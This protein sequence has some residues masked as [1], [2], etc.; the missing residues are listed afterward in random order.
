LVLDEP[1][2]GLDSEVEKMVLNA[3]CK[4][5]SE[6]TIVIAS[7]SAEIVSM[8][9]RILVIDKGRQ[10]GWG[11]PRSSQFSVPLVS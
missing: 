1:T 5:K 10:I 8:A 2:S 3:L 4:L 6:V 9:D 11:A 7:H